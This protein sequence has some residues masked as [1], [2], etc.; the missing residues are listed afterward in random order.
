MKTST[1]LNIAKAAASLGY[2]SHKEASVTHLISKKNRQAVTG[3][4][5]NGVAGDVIGVVGL[6]FNKK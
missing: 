2:I 6:F 5:V 4:I 1:K 3:K